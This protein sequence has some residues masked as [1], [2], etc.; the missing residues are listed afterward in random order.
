MKMAS[1]PA[2]RSG[3]YSGVLNDDF[4]YGCLLR[5]WSSNSF[6]EITVY[7]E[8]SPVRTKAFIKQ[9]VWEIFDKVFDYSLSASISQMEALLTTVKLLG[10]SCR[11]RELYLM[12]TEKLAGST[13][14]SEPCCL[15]VLLS[16]MQIALFDSSSSIFISDAFSL[17]LKA[18][19]RSLHTVNEDATEKTT[20]NASMQRLIKIS[21]TF[22]LGCAAR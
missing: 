16:A 2:S 8:L 1:A 9:Y 3:D 21:L 22:A 6:H 17:I 20:K 7:A 12:V 13:H 4:D 19:T 18:L 10:S 11:P 14:T 15:S 5:D